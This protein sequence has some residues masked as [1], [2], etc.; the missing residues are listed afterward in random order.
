M[1]ENIL[2]NSPPPRGEYI[3]T[4]EIEEAKVRLLAWKAANENATKPMTLKDVE[5]VLNQTLKHDHENKLMVFL[6]MLMN[7]TADDQQN[8][9]FN[10]PSSTGKSY[11]ALEIAKLFPAEDIDKKG[12]TSP[13]AFFH[14]MGKLCRVN[15]EPLEDRNKYIE[16]CLDEWDQKHP[17]PVDEITRV[18]GNKEEEI[19]NPA[20][21]Q[22]KV[23]RKT[24]YR[25]SREEW[26]NID[27]IYVVSLEKRILIFKDQ[28]H[29]RVLQVLRSMLSH[30]EKVLEVDITDKTKEG[31]HRTKKIRVIGFPTVVFC[32]A[33]FSLDEQEKTRF[34]IL[35]PDMSQAKLKESLS[36][37][38]NKL[39][40][41]EAFKSTL[42]ADAKR[43]ALMHRIEAIKAS[44]VKQIIIP[45]D[46][47]NDL[48]DW[49]TK[50]RELSPRDQRDFPRLI[51]LVK[52]HALFKMFER[53]K[54]A[55]GSITANRDDV[56][57]TKELLNGVLEANRL[58]LPPYIHKFYVESLEPAITGDG[59][60]RETLNRL[61]FAQFK[62][63]LGEKA[64]KR[65]I[66][67]L[68]ETGLIEEKPD[69]DDKRKMRMY[70]PLGEVEKNKNNFNDLCKDCKKPITPGNLSLWKGVD[71]ICSECAKA[72][73]HKLR[74]PSL[75]GVGIDL[76]TEAGE[77]SGVS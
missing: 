58:G 32:S 19:R 70:I 64:R 9:L 72:R 69:P 37:Q 20:L 22:W 49:F 71:R 62:D 66:D 57:A 67:L 76:P 73:A 6:T 42:D 40:D 35:S 12:Y 41:K 51:D 68:S 44:N 24:E 36:L 7:Y 10:A 74:N 65:L 47:S 48:L 2:N 75:E 61:Y 26:D 1:S 43:A 27:K 11:I 18:K 30:D 52:A 50:G 23:E 54:T 34:W 5:E 4:P 31:G 55:D 8:L 29:D 3:S 21:T 39:S 16:E 59:I 28:P 38:A 17:K 45:K 33:N 46:L 60:T 25:K 53:D 77:N 56:D 15:G 63:R 14:V 13:T